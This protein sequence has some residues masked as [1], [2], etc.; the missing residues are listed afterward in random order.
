MNCYSYNSTDYDVFYPFFKPALE[1]YHKVDLDT[2][3]HVN[4]WDFKGV[5]G[6]KIFK[7]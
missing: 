7:K 3:K 5:K 4:N 1:A 6:K 2:K